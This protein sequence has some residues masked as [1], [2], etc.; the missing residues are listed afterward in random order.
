MRTEMCGVVALSL[1]LSACGSTTAQRAATGGL[2]GAGIGA[3]AG[4]PVG[5]VIGGLAGGAAGGLM[6]EGV[7]KMAKNYFHR[8]HEPQTAAVSE[9]VSHPPPSASQASGTSSPPRSVQTAAAEQ[10]DTASLPITPELAR[11]IQSILKDE[12][13]YEGPVDGII[14]RGTRTALASYQARHGLPATAV[15]DQGTMEALA[16]DDDSLSGSSA[17]APSQGTPAPDNGPAK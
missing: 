17:P 15:V 13:F 4:G 6:T 1:L 11:H 3:L 16:T 14:G 7:D 10:P 8:A 12:G 2:T 9:N 5:L